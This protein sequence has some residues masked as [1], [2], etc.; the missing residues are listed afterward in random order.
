MVLEITAVVGQSV[1]E[2]NRDYSPALARFRDLTAFWADGFE[3][4]RAPG[5]L[6]IRGSLA[7]ISSQ[8]RIAASSKS[9]ASTGS[10]CQ[11]V[12]F[13]PNA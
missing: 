6:P 8:A 7:T 10:T 4:R 9:A 12:T 11:P 13:V 3:D 2:S 5:T 1:H